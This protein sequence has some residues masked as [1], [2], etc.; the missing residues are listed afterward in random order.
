MP[1]SLL[2]LLQLCNS[3]LPLGAFSYSESLETLV[4]KQLISDD[5]GLKLWL[6]NEL[7]Y[8]SIRVESAIML[9]GY[10]CFLSQ[11]F[12]KL[13][14]WNSWLTAQRETLELRQQS[15]QMGKSLMRLIHSLEPE[16]KLIIELNSLFKSNCNYA[17]AFGIVASN[18]QIA[19][20]NAILGYLYSW[21]NNLVNAGVKLIPL[22]QTMG[23][24]ILLEMNNHLVKITQEILTLDDDDL[25]SCSI[26]L[27]LASMQHEVEYSRLF[28][29]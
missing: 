20:E 15:W 14:Y 18:W 29:S 25:A 3:S 16:N 24:K 10:N 7:S 26:G 13:N 17:I 1:N 22:G 23:Q 8:G 28:R 19:P 12:S 2:S 5:Y 6:I 27:S 4:N 9:R 21:M 11:D